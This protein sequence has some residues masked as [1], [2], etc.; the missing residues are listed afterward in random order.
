M[1]KISMKQAI[2]F[3]TETDKYK[4]LINLCN[5]MEDNCTIAE[6]VETIYIRKA[7]DA[8]LALLCALA[9]DPENDGNVIANHDAAKLFSD[10]FE[11]LFE[12]IKKYCE[13]SY[14]EGSIKLIAEMLEN[15]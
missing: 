13:E 4:A 8:A 14:I 7:I 2:E 15:N 10:Q 3:L 12:F 9:N 5:Y 6:R 1:F 11:C